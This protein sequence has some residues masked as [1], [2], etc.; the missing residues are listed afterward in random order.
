MGE[1]I[2]DNS[3]QEK[4]LLN[5]FAVLIVSCWFTLDSYWSYVLAQIYFSK[6]VKDYLRAAEK[7]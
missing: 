6:L 5:F 3:S 1:N 7:Q 2:L 4:Y